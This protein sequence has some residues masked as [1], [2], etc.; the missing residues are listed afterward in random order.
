MHNII[1]CN[2]KYYYYQQKHS[3]KFPIT[4]IHK[5]IHTN[6]QTLY[7]IMMMTLLLL[8]LV[9]NQQ[10]N[11][12][13]NYEPTTHQPKKKKRKNKNTFALNSNEYQ[14]NCRKRKKRAFLMIFR[15]GASSICCY[16]FNMKVWNGI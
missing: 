3:H 15:R 12:K 14:R 2:N 7:T 10:H 8:R 4:H 1:K 6:R 16:S 13:T 11:V 9:F 5:C